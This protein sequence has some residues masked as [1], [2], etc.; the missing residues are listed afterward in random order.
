MDTISIVLGLSRLGK[1]YQKKRS[2]NFS[3]AHVLA[4]LVFDW[5]RWRVSGIGPF[6]SCL[7]GFHTGQT[8]NRPKCVNTKPV[9]WSQVAIFRL[10]KFSLGKKS[11]SSSSGSCEGGGF[12]NLWPVSSG[13]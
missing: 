11:L 1:R 5:M 7:V 4:S 2:K 3:I 12:V 10:E 6:L 9:H 13:T 8:V